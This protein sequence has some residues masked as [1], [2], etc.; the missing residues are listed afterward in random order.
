MNTDNE[1]LDLLRT[2]FLPV[3]LS[4]KG[5]EVVD[6]AEACVNEFQQVCNRIFVF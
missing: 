5:R 4:F 3:R 1:I 2:Y 6:A